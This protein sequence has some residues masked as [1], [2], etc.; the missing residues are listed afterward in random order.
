MEPAGTEDKGIGLT[1]LR[2]KAEMKSDKRIWGSH[3]GEEI[4][5]HYKAYT[6]RSGG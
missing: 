6:T 4:T 3:G 5:G 2:H 1:Y